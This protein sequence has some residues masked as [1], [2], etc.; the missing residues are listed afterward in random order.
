[1][2]LEYSED[3]RLF[4]EAVARFL[5]KEY[6]FARRRRELESGNAGVWPELADMGVL[7]LPIPEALGGLGCGTVETGP[8][9]EALGAHL[10]VQSRLLSVIIVSG[11]LR[12][13][14]APEAHA[15]LLQQVAAG[16]AQIVLAHDEASERI[17]TTAVRFDRGWRISGRKQ[18]VRG[19]ADADV[20]I[21]SALDEEGALRVFLVK[22]SSQGV[23]RKAVRLLDGSLAADLA[24]SEVAVD[25]A[26]A[27]DLKDTAQTLQDSID[28]ATVAACWEAVGA[29][30]AAFLQTIDYMRQR[31]Q[32]GRPLAAFQVVQHELA[33]MA[34][35]CEEAGAAALLAT[36]TLHRGGP[37]RTRAVCAAKVKVGRCANFVAKQAV[38]LHGGMGVSEELPIASYFR[39]LT[40]FECDLGSTG[41]QRR[42]Y[43][44]T[45]VV[46]GLHRSSA[47]LRSQANAAAGAAGFAA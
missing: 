31:E 15:D 7:A 39:K 10:V 47:V 38:Q 9:M 32:F 6:D 20:L 21:V 42:R 11:I 3:Q 16:D 33:E 23:S 19:G 44:R 24:L 46:P 41:A 17:G 25:T 2:E 26:A 36:L 28:E 34:V 5:E 43:A 18:L 37:D 45:A 40:M 29:M 1:M 30:R 27:L 35:C 8:V 22:G 14:A 12:R 4:G 13:T